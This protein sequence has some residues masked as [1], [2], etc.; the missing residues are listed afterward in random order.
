MFVLIGSRKG[1][2]ENLAIRCDGPDKDIIFP[3]FQ[4]RP[5]TLIECLTGTNDHE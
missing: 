4:I 3:V 5:F 1:V 2:Y